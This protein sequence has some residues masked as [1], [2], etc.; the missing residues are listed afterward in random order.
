METTT[1]PQPRPSPPVRPRLERLRHDRA[2]AGVAAGLAR[3]LDIGVGWVRLAFIVTALFGGAGILLYILGWLAIPEE[4]EARSIAAERVDGLEGVG[5]WIGIGLIVIAVLIIVGN[6]GLVS[7][8]LLFAAFLIGLGILLY[9]GDLGAPPRRRENRERPVPP[10]PV[11]GAGEPAP[12]SVPETTAS[13][14]A[15]TASL[16]GVAADVVAAPP[17]TEPPVPP[18][19]PPPHQAFQPS[20]PPRSRAPRP[21]RPPRPPKERSPL[22]RY[23]VAAGLIVLGVLGIGQ[24]SGWFDLEPRHIAAA[25]LIVLGAGLLVGSLWGRARWLIVFGIIIAPLLAGMALLRTPLTGGFGDPAYSPDNAAQLQSEYRLV[26]GEM[27]LDL[28]DLELTPGDIVAV[29]ASV[30][31]GRL[32]VIVPDRLNVDVVARVDA[33]EIFLDGARGSRLGR[34]AD[35]IH[36]ERTISYGGDAPGDVSLVVHVGFGEVSV[37]QVEEDA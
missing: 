2:I 15:A 5:S 13:V 21:P 6:S 24:A 23:T 25:V 29:D 18:A 35:N 30:V 27:T 8:D 36:L 17:T 10:A 37:Y 14:A 12:T 26:A 33:G 9:R 16:S 32:E 11:P 31:F 34:V 28:T 22:G 4:G 20:R 7:G 19:S 3:H 1:E